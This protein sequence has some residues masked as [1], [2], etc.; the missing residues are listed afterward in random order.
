MFILPATLHRHFY[1]KVKS[2]VRDAGEFLVRT[3]WNRGAH[4][5]E[6]VLIDRKVDGCQED[7]KLLSG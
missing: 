4:R 6:H 3:V 2:I 7:T 1:E 5:D